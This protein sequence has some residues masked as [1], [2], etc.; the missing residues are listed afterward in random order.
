MPCSG[1]G[2]P[3]HS[4]DDEMQQTATITYWQFL[5]CMMATGLLGYT[6]G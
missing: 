5:L 6:A 3:P 2:R 1:A 4:E